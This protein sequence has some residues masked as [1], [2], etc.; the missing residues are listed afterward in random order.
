M[1]LFEREA[2]DILAALQDGETITSAQLLARM[3]IEPEGR[4][5][6]VL[7]KLAQTSMADCASRG[8]P[9]VKY[10]KSMRPWLWHAPIQEEEAPELNP[11]ALEFRINQIQASLDRIEHRL[12]HAPW[13]SPCLVPGRPCPEGCC[14]EA[15]GR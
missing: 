7:R 12:N 3:N 5:F 2:R 15:E 13:S 1:P 14:E 4:A 8:A 6:E 11:E 10:G 9:Y